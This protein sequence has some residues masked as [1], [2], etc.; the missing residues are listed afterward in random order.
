MPARVAPL[1]LSDSDKRQLQQWASAYG[2]PQQVALR[3]RIVLAAADGQSD[4]AI[5]QQLESNRPT[6]RLWRARF[7]QKGLQGLWEV[8]PGRGRKPTYD[9][10]KIQQVIDTTLQSKPKGMNPVELPLDGPAPRRSASR[11]S[12]TSGRA[13]ICKPHRVKTFKLSRDPKFLEKINRRGGS[14]SE[15]TRSR[16]SCC[17]WMKRAKFRPWIAPNR[18]CPSRRVAAGP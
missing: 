7:A 12:A 2:T 5:A 9:A 4:N 14:V 13:T 15:S 18:A 16:R 17:A 11:R 6:V 1:S 8:A 3:C 10:E